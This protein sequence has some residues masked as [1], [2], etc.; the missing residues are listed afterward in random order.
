MLA[1]IKSI[2]IWAS[3]ALLTLSWLPIVA[4]VWLFD[5]DPAKYATGRVFRK[6]GHAYTLLNPSWKIDLS[7][8]F[9]GTPRRPYVVV[10]NHQ[11]HADVPIISRLPIEMKWVSKSDILK[12][13]VVGWMMKMAGDI[14]VYRGQKNKKTIVFKMSSRYLRRKCS[15]F[16]FPEG[17]RSKTKLVNAFTDGA[18]SLAIKYK[19]PVLPLAIDGSSDCLPKNDWVFKKV[20]HIKMKI[21]EPISTDNLSMEQVDEL[22]DKVRQMI[23]NQIADWRGIDAASVDALAIQKAV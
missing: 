12:V 3:V 18:F 17:T 10:S 4:I 13:P 23:I 8:S 6:L 14:P 21:F 16:F 9:P 2:L 1:K 22:K 5:R 20:S 15:I 19:V 7:G 11:S